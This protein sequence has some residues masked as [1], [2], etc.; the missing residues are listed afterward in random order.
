MVD[1]P[2]VVYLTCCWYT[3]Y[4]VQFKVHLIP[5]VSVSDIDCY[6][7]GLY[8]GHELLLR[9]PKLRN[10]PHARH[11]WLLWLAMGTPQPLSPLYKP[12][13]LTPLFSDL[14]P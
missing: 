3:R 1:W 5:P 6:L 10:R 2:G 9:H 12:L 13:V 14:H 8:I 7:H 4:E 11:I